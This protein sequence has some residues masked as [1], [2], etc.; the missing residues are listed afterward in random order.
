V[1]FPVSTIFLKNI[2]FP[3]MSVADY[4]FFLVF[5]FL[6]S[7]LHCTVFEGS[8]YAR[9]DQS[10]LP[11]TLH[12][13]IFLSLSKVLIQQLRLNFTRKPAS[14]VSDFCTERSLRSFSNLDSALCTLSSICIIAVTHGTKLRG[15]KTLTIAPNTAC[16]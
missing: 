8:S 5:P 2:F 16:S 14:C 7:F 15:A 3:F 4:V 10:L 13:L 6:L 12:I 1:P 9:Y 11:I